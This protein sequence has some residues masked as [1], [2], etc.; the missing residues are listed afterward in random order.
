[1]KAVFNLPWEDLVQHI[2]RKEYE[3]LG[4]SGK[5][6]FMYWEENHT[7]VSDPKL[8]KDILAARSE[9]AFMMV[10]PLNTGKRTFAALAARRFPATD[11]SPL[12]FAEGNVADHSERQM[13]KRFFGKHGI[14]DTNRH[15]LIFFDP[16]ESMAGWPQFTDKLHML[17]IHN[18]LGRL[19][20]QVIDVQTRIA[21][22]S[23]RG[24]EEFVRKDPNSLFAN[25]YRRV[26]EVRFDLPSL[27]AS[28]NSGEG[29]PS[30][31]L[32][33]LLASHV[34]EHNLSLD[35]GRKQLDPV[36]T[37]SVKALGILR[38]YDWPDQFPELR[39]LVDQAIRAGGWEEAIRSNLHRPSKEQLREGDQQACGKGKRGDPPCGSPIRPPSVAGRPWYEGL[40]VWESRA[41]A[42]RRS[43]RPIGRNDCKSQLM[44]KGRG[45]DIFLWGGELRVKGRRKPVKLGH[46]LYYLLVMFLRHRSMP[47]PVRSSYLKAWKKTRDIHGYKDTDIANDFLKPA[48]QEL[49]K[50]IGL[51]RNRFS[52]SKAIGTRGFACTGKFTFYAV[53][54]SDVA[55]T[56]DELDLQEVPTPP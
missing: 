24:L 5:P 17:L 47:L 48:V 32:A 13:L 11:K 31:I 34:L 8:I 45:H 33:E 43:V 12:P 7:F 29:R 22:G 2:R 25:V 4:P 49:L 55:K 53:I 1:M 35:E 16:F 46:R 10:S 39:R 19:D 27:S 52:I 51:P 14:V 42:S 15:A 41:S 20:G 23:T 36:Q 50:K 26:S 18:Q 44:E 21:V 28:M 3:P 38:D 54:R 56:C 6:K 37:I 30:E 9:N 40:V